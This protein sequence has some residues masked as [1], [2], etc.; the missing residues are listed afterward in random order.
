MPGTVKDTGDL[1]GHTEVIPTFKAYSLMI[2][3]AITQSLSQILLLPTKH[4]SPF[5][6]VRVP[7]WSNTIP[8]SKPWAWFIQGS[9][10]FVLEMDIGTNSYRIRCERKPAGG[11]GKSFLSLPRESYRERQS[12]SFLRV[13]LYLQGM[14]ESAEPF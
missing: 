1:T 4:P 10:A 12:L 3:V 13:V 11:F 6:S 8:S 2:I 9:P 14:P 5:L 7:T